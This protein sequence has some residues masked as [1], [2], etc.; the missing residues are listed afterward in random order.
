[1]HAVGVL[2]PRCH[3]QLQQT[4]RE[5]LRWQPENN[6]L[7]RSV[8]FGHAAA[9]AAAAAAAAAVLARTCRC[10]CSGTLAEFQAAPP[11]PTKCAAAM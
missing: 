11:R 10:N 1:M 6:W 8:D 7:P 5:Q 3:L 9:V 2:P 4:P